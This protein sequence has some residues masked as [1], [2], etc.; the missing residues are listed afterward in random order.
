MENK[1]GIILL[2]DESNIETVNIMQLLAESVTTIRQNKI[3]NSVKDFKIKEEL[4]DIEVV[5]IKALEAMVE[6]LIFD[7]AKE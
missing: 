2:L 7:L 6:K 3:I 5:I 1:N 4:Y